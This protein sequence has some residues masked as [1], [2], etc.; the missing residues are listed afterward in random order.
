MFV[1]LQSNFN[2][3]RYTVIGDDTAT[4][5]FTVNANTGLI[6]ASGDLTIENVDYYN[7]STPSSQYNDSFM[8]IVKK[9][10]HLSSTG[11]FLSAIK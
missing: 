10:Q 3:I 1:L 5:Y 6:T 11:P 9:T 2:Q 7:V 8:T 4:D